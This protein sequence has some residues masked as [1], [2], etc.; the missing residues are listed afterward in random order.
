MGLDDLLVRIFH[1]D[2]RISGIVVVII[3]VAVLIHSPSHCPIAL[4]AGVLAFGV[5]IPEGRET[6]GAGSLQGT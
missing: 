3:V 2:Q 6:H 5:R 4:L 1:L